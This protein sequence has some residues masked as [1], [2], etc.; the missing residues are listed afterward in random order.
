MEYSEYLLIEDALNLKCR[1][2]SCLR[3]ANIH[4]MKELLTYNKKR[5]FQLD[6]FGKISYIDIVENCAKIG[7]EFPSKEVRIADAVEELI[8]ALRRYMREDDVGKV[9]KTHKFVCAK[10]ALENIEKELSEDD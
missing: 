5:L 7:I 9:L 3:N 4:I 1:T 6:N 10:E 2:R 8:T